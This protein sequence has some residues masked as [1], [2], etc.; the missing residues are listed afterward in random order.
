M[1]LS[2]GDLITYAIFDSSGGKALLRDCYL[3]N[4][5]IVSPTGSTLCYASVIAITQVCYIVLHS[6]SLR[7]VYFVYVVLLKIKVAT[8][9]P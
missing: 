8:Y 2:R 1:F 7:F 3:R 5:V 4:I 6:V 9:Q